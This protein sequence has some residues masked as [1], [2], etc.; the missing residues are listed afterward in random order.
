MFQLYKD[1]KIAYYVIALSV[2]I[3]L[4]AY[5]SWTE[6]IGLFVWALVIPLIIAIVIESIAIKRFNALN[7]IREINCNIAEY[8]SELEKLRLNC[9]NAKQDSISCIS[10]N[11]THPFQSFIIK[12][13]MGI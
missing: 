6:K 9:K 8:C 13:N 12:G 3:P 10:R 11:L 1:L 5:A 2:A 7:K 4:A